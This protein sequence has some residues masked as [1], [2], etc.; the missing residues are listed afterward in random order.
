MRNIT[1]DKVLN[2]KIYAKNN[3]VK[4]FESDLKTVKTNFKKDQLIGT[5]YSYIES[6]NG[7]YW[8][9]YLT[10]ADFHN[11][12]AVFI[13]HNSN[14]L[15]LPELPQILQQISSEKSK[16]EIAEKGVIQYNIDKYLP[17]I[18]GGISLAFILPALNNNK[19]GAMKK[20]DKALIGVGIAA[21]GLYFITKKKKLKSGTPI[22]SDLQSGN[23]T[24][25][26]VEENL[27]SSSFVAPG[28]GTKNFFNNY[29]G[30]PKI[31]FIGPF[32]V[33]YF[34]HQINGIKKGNL[35]K[36]KTI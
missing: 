25:N 8:M 33:E 1:A 20:N 13:K 16:K 34:K 28:T 2:K 31:N 29:P 12:R 7:L 10:R 27:S 19:V 30:E 14:D 11:F 21:V 3:S 4:A 9:V 17:Y 18:V 6:V 22:V 24:K 5:V 23:I 15:F 32:E 35:G 36:I 26:A